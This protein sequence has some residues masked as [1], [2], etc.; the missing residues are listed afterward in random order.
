MASPDAM[1]RQWL[2]GGP[3][4]FEPHP[5]EPGV[6]SAALDASGLPLSLGSFQLALSRAGH[7]PRQSRDPDGGGYRWHLFLPER[8]RADP[9]HLPGRRSVVD[10]R[11]G[12]A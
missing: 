4:S 1:V 10:R 6:L 9:Q 8:E 7:V 2:A 5:T 3:G 12:Q 11:G